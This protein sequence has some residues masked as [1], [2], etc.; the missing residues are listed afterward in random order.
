M[1]WL[2]H[3]EGSL[4]VGINRVGWCMRALPNEA[5]RP[6]IQFSGGTLSAEMAGGKVHP[7]SGF[8]FAVCQLRPESRGHIRIKSP[9]PLKTPE[10]QPNYLSTDLD[11]RTAVAAIRAA[12]KI[13]QSE[14]LRTYIQREVKQGSGKKSNGDLPEFAPP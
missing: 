5:S 10:I 14:A 9:N 1:Q 7:Y 4:A 12:R 13:A 2:V 6:D 11:R 8:T 3:R